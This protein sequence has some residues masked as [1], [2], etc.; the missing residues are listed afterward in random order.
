LVTEDIG[1]VGL[2]LSAAWFCD[3]I[4]YRNSAGKL[5][6]V[7]NLAWLP[8]RNAAAVISPVDF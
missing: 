5:N 6:I 1:P 3:V 7:I 2:G 8:G 4:Y